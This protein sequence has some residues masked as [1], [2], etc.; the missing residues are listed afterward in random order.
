VQPLLA[1]LPAGVQPAEAAVPLAHWS[2]A[3]VPVG[4]Q[5]S[6]CPTISISS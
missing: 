2:L 3:A 1:E 4:A 5:T 6:P